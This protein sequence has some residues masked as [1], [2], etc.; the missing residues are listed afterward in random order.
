ML[1]V[2]PTPAE[3]GGTLLLP[4]PQSLPAMLAEA[5]RRLAHMNFDVAGVPA[6][7]LRR[8]ARAELLAAVGGDRP[9]PWVIAAHQSEMHHAG[10][11]FKDAVAAALAEAAG[12]AAFHL[13]ADH[14][15]VGH[16]ALTVPQTDAEG[17]V[18]QVQAVYASPAP[19][20]C[21]AQLPPPAPAEVESLVAAVPT[22]L[23]ESAT[24]AHW[25][26]AA[27]S[28]TGTARTLAE[29]AAA[30]RAAVTES[31]H[32]NVPNAFISRLVAG[33]AFARFAADLIVRH[34]HMLAV[35]NA[36]LADHRAAC[37]IHNP[38]RPVP[39]LKT[40]DGATEVP[41]WVYRAD[42]PR[43]PLLART[44]HGEI[45]LLTPAGRLA[46]CPADPEAVAAAV[47][48]LTADGVVLTPRAI[49]LTMFVRTFFA[50]VFVHGIGGTI[51]ERFGDVLIE[52]WFGWRPPA[53]VT[54]TATVRL[55]LPRSDLTAADLARALWHR[56]HAWHNPNLY[57][58]GELPASASQLVRDKT[59]ALGQ[60][61]AAPRC[62]PARAARFADVHRINAAWA[63]P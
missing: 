47:A 40:V 16:A 43:E 28:A 35:H 59:D 50:E 11:W 9:A 7:T 53:F 60:L 2:P 13:V 33:E 18:H 5:G 62:G 52:R 22:P 29:W 51:Y 61:A 44:R 12:G 41:L 20:Q 26:R 42:G 10:V 1:T 30:A 58:G 6:A 14:D 39:P 8:Q 32:L 25:A 27:R 63:T 3:D 21:P 49:T 34:E 31:L 46:A 55:D 24:F 37:G 48:Q 17:R 15:T 54:A 56:H 57:A 4:H 19:W 38:T 45:E 23:R 36:A